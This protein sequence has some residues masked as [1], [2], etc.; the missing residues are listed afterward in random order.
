LLAGAKSERSE[1]YPAAH[2][3]PPFRVPGLERLFRAT[4]VLFI[5]DTT[6]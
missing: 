5:L 2:P 3:A 1:H 6:L 4:R